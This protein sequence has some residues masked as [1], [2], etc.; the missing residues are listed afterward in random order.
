MLVLDLIKSRLFFYSTLYILHLKIS[1]AVLVREGMVI[2]MT[3][4]IPEVRSEKSLTL[5]TF[6]I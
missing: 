1:S 5:L 4:G 3:G 2:K 6:D